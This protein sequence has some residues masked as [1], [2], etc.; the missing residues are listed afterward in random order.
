MD[1]FF[2]T[3][4]RQITNDIGKF[5]NNVLGPRGIAFSLWVV[6]SIYSVSLA[7]GNVAWRTFGAVLDEFSTNGNI[8]IFA[9]SKTT[10]LPY[11]VFNECPEFA[12]W[13]Y[14]SQANS[15]YESISSRVNSYFL[16]SPT[17]L[18]WIM[19][20]VSC[21][22]LNSD[23]EYKSSG[24]W[25]LDS[26]VSEFF[27]SVHENYYIDPRIILSCWSIQSGICYRD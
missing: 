15:L 4:T 24:E 14:N 2:D 7:I 6:S 12:K 9:D 26:W 20:V 13:F 10:P 19:S 25:Y 3:F 27:M 18:P 17:K 23:G 1:E 22:K 8:W 5:A 16:T 21:E 11:K